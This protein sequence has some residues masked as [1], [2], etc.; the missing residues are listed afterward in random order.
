MNASKTDATLASVK[1]LQNEISAWENRLAEVH[2]KVE[3]LRK[4]KDSLEKEIEEK[5]NRCNQEIEKK[6]MDAR[7]YAAEVEESRKRLI[8]DKEEFQNIITQFK[9]E[10]NTLEREKQSA[11]DMK[12]DAQKQLNKCGEF[13]R[14]V[15]DGSSKL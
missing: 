10:R 14:M 15:R 5:M 3:G 9:Q 8:T 2:S 1:Q 7:K 6:Y 12:N 11:L 13:I 4:T